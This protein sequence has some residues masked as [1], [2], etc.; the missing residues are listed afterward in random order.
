MGPPH[1]RGGDAE[2]EA[3]TEAVD[4]ASMGPPHVRGGDFDIPNAFAKVGRPLQ[5][6]RRMFAAETPD[7]R[8]VRGY[9]VELQWGRR[10]FAA[11]TGEIAG[12]WSEQG[13]A[14]MGPPHVRGGDPCNW[15]DD[16][17][18]E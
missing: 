11:E 7:K 14:S 15:D 13:R 1:V 17:S 10:M 4:L 8:G 18:Q 12:R 5:W 6:G 3:L 16:A 2:S 9:F